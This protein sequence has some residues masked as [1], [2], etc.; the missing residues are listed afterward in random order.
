M[1]IAKESL[2]D[3]PV[4]DVAGFT[5][6]HRKEALGVV[7]VVAPWNYPYMCMINSIVPALLAGQ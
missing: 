4:A 5:R 7:V 2:K 1:S 3:S 6:F